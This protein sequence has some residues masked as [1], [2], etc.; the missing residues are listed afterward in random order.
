M[1]PR[2][3]TEQFSSIVQLTILN[4]HYTLGCEMKCRAKL[5]IL[6]S[7]VFITQNQGLATGMPKTFLERIWIVREQIRCL[8]LL[9]QSKSVP[10]L[11]ILTC[12]KLWFMKGISK[13]VI[14]GQINHSHTFF[15]ACDTYGHIQH[16]CQTS[17]I[18]VR[19]SPN[20]K[21]L[22]IHQELIHWD[23]SKVKQQTV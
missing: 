22:Q 1:E 12:S 10:L 7:N 15:Y 21:Y 19:Q 18:E 13:L 23:N 9:N 4:Q 14:L 20:T 3:N 6:Y 11:A 16:R 17:R 5:L 8:V 2:L